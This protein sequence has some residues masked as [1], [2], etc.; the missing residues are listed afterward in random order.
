MI[1]KIPI[2]WLQLKFEKLKL[3]VSIFGITFAVVLMFVQLGLRSGMFDGALALPRSVSGEIVLISPRSPSMIFLS[4]F[5]KS[6]LIQ[7]LALEEV[8]SVSPVYIS[9]LRWQNPQIEN[10]W[11]NICTIGISTE[12]KVLDIPGL[13]EN[14]NKIK[15]A[16]RV[17]FN[18]SSRSEFGKI[19]EL[20][21]SQGQVITD[22]SATVLNLT[23][24][25][26]VVG[27]FNLP[28][29]FGLDGYLLTSEFNFFELLNWSSDNISLGVIKLKNGSNVDR[30]YYQ[31]KEMF[32]SAE[33]L[34]LT[35]QELI[36]FEQ[37]YWDSGS[38]IGFIF[39]FG[40]ILGFTIGIIIVYQILYSNVSEHLAE[41]AT[42]KAMGYKHRFLLVVVFQESIIL[43]ILGYIPGFFITNT[44]YHYSQTAIKIPI[45]M[46]LNRALI[47]LV[48][49]LLMCLISGAVAVRKLK[50]ADPADI[51]R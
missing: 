36:E 46:E 50:G 23:H 11:R 31:L 20:F 1:H 7:S 9:W 22:V 8:E 29:S 19:V 24:R 17:L 3:L 45:F 25:I 15:L 10:I 12:R 18:E 14:I 40:M 32:K 13:Q 2:A 33:V 44:I 4:P 5:S 41:Y 30:V 37:K 39:W 34:V 28:I 35:K 21:K 47:V 42:L 16:D 38:P 48:I 6:Y 27:L 51:F 26:K 43:A 49:T